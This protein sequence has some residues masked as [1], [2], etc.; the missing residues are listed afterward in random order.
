MPCAIKIGHVA[1][2]QWVTAF[3]RGNIEVGRIKDAL[4]VSESKAAEIVAILAAQGIPAEVVAISESRGVGVRPPVRCT[5][6]T[7][8]I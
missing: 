6:Q 8:P 7:I 4:A 5:G 2:P 3:H 1:C